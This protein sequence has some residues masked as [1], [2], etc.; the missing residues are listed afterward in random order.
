MH[1]EQVRHEGLPHDASR[2]ASS[3]PRHCST[4]G[5]QG[6]IDR[7]L[8]QGLAASVGVFR[9]PVTHPMFRN[10]GPAERCIVV[11]PRTSVWIHHEGSRPFVADP[12][13]VTIYNRAQ[14]YERSPLAPDGDRCDWLGVSDDVARDIVGAFDSADGERARGP[15]GFE[16]A[17]ST[18]ELYLKQ[19]RL[20]RRVANGSAAPLEVESEVVALVEQVMA[21]A[22]H[23]QL[24]PSPVLPAT[25]RRRRDIVELAKAELWSSM[26]ENRSLRDIAQSVGTS[27]FHLCRIFRDVTHQSLHAY[28]LGLRL[29]VALERLAQERGTLASVAADLGF[30]GH[31][32]LVRLCQRHYGA[33]PSALRAQLRNRTTSQ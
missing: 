25:A 17:P 33:P 10:S 31:A 27:V 15:F 30:A 32:H 18:P 7:P 5:T 20:L 1:T 28:R 3:L 8:Y 11:F 14:C 26:A 23:R 24:E 12:N 19:R 4:Y 21:A 13:V 22:Y 16:Y 9:C 2:H 6:L 29:R